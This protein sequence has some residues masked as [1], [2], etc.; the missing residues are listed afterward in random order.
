Q[1]FFIGMAQWGCSNER[2]EALRLQ[3]LTDVHAPNRYRINGVVANMPEFARAFACRPGQA[4]VRAR[5]CRV[6]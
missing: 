1:R 4:M 3:A 6:W 2:P 5:R